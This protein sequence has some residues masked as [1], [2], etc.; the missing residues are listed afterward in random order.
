[1][2]KRL[3]QHITSVG[4]RGGCPTAMREEINPSVP[5]VHEWSTFD[6]RSSPPPLL[7]AHP[8]T[9]T[10]HRPN[11]KY[12]PWFNVPLK[13]ARVA[14]A[15]IGMLANESRASRVSFGDV[16]KRLAD[17]PAD[18]GLF[19]SKKVCVCEEYEEC[20]GVPTPAA[21]LLSPDQHFHPLTIVLVPPPQHPPTPSPQPLSWTASSAS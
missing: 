1:M 18:S 4:R 13:S 8:P 15:V 19:I 21:F 20:E 14:V 17:E 9:H 12:V 3:S 6:G 2:Q 5:Y 10:Q 7:P 16:V 11:P